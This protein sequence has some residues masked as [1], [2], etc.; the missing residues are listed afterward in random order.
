MEPNLAQRSPT[1][2]RLSRGGVDWNRT[3]RR[4]RW[5]IRR[6]SHGGVDW[7]LSH[8]PTRR[9]T[10]VAS[11]A[12]AWIGTASSAGWLEAWRRLS[13]GGVDWNSC[14]LRSLGAAVEV[15]SHAEA[16]IG[17]LRHQLRTQS[18][19][20]RLSRGGV[21]W[22]HL[23]CARQALVTVASHAEAWIGTTVDRL[24]VCAAQVASHAEAWIGTRDLRSPAR[25]HCRLSRGGVDWNNTWLDAS[26]RTSV[27]SHAEAWI[28]TLP[29]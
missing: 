8:T 14:I 21:D 24:R 26:R 1:G 10:T 5:R 3:M 13:R 15:A 9:S 25:T 27:A 20:S 7:N 28:G 12:E 11:H 18:H 2:G 19:A 4:Q 16:W 22:N 29:C 23:R 17:T 6:L